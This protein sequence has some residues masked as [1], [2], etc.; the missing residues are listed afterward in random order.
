VLAT[1]VAMLGAAAPAGANWGSNGECSENKHCY[2]LA[3]RNNA[4]KYADID[5]V[6]TTLSDVPEWARGAF[7]SNETW[8]SWEDQGIPGWIET[9]S[10][11]GSLAGEE[12]NPH[13]FFAEEQKG[14]FQ[15]HVDPIPVPQSA[16]V[17]YMLDDNERNG[18]WR[19]FWG[20]AGSCG[21][22]WCEVGRYGGGW[23][24]TLNEQEAGV[25]VASNSEPYNQGRDEVAASNNGLGGPPYWEPWTGAGYLTTT[26]AILIEH[27]SEL[28]SAGN[29]AWSVW[30]G[31]AA[32]VAATTAP[33]LATYTGGTGGEVS[34]TDQGDLRI[35]H[36]TKAFK[37][38]V[39]TPRGHKRPS[40]KVETLQVNEE[41]RV[42]GVY[43]GSTPPTEEELRGGL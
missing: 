16:Y 8:I 23:P 31:Q 2:G 28:P 17:H 14:R 26:A 29:I 33:T 9:G 18:A 15:I 34:E 41:G 20:G 42:V 21:E 10:I 1:V 24:A 32:S 36:G 13:Q 22:G 39:P 11:M 30:P 27:N 6:D 7:V 25:E 35:L 37:P 40:G 38:Q 4:S 3:Y 43:L 12:Y 5:Y 19:I